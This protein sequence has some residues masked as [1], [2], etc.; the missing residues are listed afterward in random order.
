MGTATNATITRRLREDK[1]ADIAKM[2][3]RE[4]DRPTGARDYIVERILT[5]L[6]KRVKNAISLH[7]NM[8]KD[9]SDVDWLV[10]AYTA[11]VKR[12]Q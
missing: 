12:A 6:H 2:L 1:L 11:A 10:A 9:A 4:V 8:H 5:R 7:P 3:R